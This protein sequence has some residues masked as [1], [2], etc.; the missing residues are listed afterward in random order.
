MVIKKIPPHPALRQVIKC[1][2]YLENEKEE[3]I[4][5]TY[6]ADGCVEAVFSIGWQFY[7][8]E[9]KEPWAKVIG[10]IIKPRSLEIVGKGQSFGIWFYPHTFSYFTNVAL[11][12]MNDSVVSWDLLFPKSFADFVG[13]CMIENRLT[14]LVEGV[15]SFL[16]KTYSSYKTQSKD[17]LAAAAVQYLYENKTNPR[18]DE[19]ASTLNVS[20]R[21]LQ[22]IF[23]LKVGFSQ[24]FLV[25]IL[26][27]QQTLQSFSQDDAAG[28]ATLAYQNEFFDQSHFIKEF[29]IFTG[30]LPSKF[31]KQKLP[32]NQHFITAD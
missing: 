3:V 5:D 22:K 20:Q 29:K 10:Q 6:F 7:K 26:R 4:K 23:L 31:E 1:Y 9:T 14:E 17:E 27:I 30:M 18:L 25:R 15:N 2:Y 11:N 21:Y 8:D 19:V 16:M 32:I 28:L 24:K 13:N 12:E